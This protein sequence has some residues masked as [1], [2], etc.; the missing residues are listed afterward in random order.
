MRHST[1]RRI[2][3]RPAGREAAAHNKENQQEQQFFGETMHESF[4]KPPTALQQPAVQRKCDD[5]EKE[6]KVQKKEDKK[7]EDQQV[8]KK[9]NDST[10]SAGTPSS[11]TNNLS[12][13]GNPLPK[14]AQQF[15]GARMGYDFSDVKVHTDKDAADSA[16]AIHAKA[17]TLGNNIVFNEGEYNS[18][19]NEGKKLMAHELTHVMQQHKK[20]VHRK[21]ADEETKTE[22]LSPNE[23]DQPQKEELAPVFVAGVGTNTENKIAFANC[24]GVSVEGNTVANYDHGTYSA[25]SSSVTKAESCDGCTENDCLTIVGTV[26]SIFQAAPVVTLPNVPAG[27]NE[28]EHTVVQSFIDG[29]LSQ[30]EQ[31]HVA[32]FN[33]YNGTVV[34][35]F[36]YTGCRAGFDA[37]IL[38]MH[39]RIEAARVISANILSDAL[40]PFNP[41]IPC[42]CPDPE[43]E[44]APE[45]DTE[46]K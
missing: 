10:V 15:F 46:T 34:T 5:C 39:N 27:L 36:S 6:E 43:P 21:Q 29:T 17:Y 18:E 20:Q 19:S 24:E 32:A 45:A 40:D 31:Q 25:S 3:R 16:K 11:Y 28:C 14:S 13:K 12:G 8:Q 37:H 22:E 26:Q 1:N 42:E 9:G 33:T 4:F 2:R 35:P 30:H 41:T 38:A 44:Q 23:I 7:E